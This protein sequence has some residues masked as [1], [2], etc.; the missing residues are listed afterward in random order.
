MITTDKG[1]AIHD[2]LVPLY[3]TATDK[4]TRCQ[5]SHPVGK[6]G[7]INL[8]GLSVADIQGLV[9]GAGER[10]EHL[11]NLLRDKYSYKTVLSLAE[12]AEW[13]ENGDIA[14]DYCRLVEWQAFE[15]EATASDLLF[16]MKEGEISNVVKCAAA[17]RHLESI[18]TSG[19]KV[20]EPLAATATEICFALQSGWEPRMIIGED[21]LVGDSAT[22]PRDAQKLYTPQEW[23]AEDAGIK[24]GPLE[25]AINAEGEL[26]RWGTL[27]DKEELGLEAV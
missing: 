17:L 1:E 4:W 5:W 2:L 25:W 10:V 3:Q 12:V 13:M 23:I 27:V 14:Q 7:L 16:N 21:C 26:L 18:R 19:K 15:S 11:V 20:W 8:K 22:T 24:R 9:D 6:L